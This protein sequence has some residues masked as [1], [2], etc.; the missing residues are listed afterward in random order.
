MEPLCADS[1]SDLRVKDEPSDS[2]SAIDGEDDVALAKAE[3]VDL[4]VLLFKVLWNETGAYAKWCSYVDRL[5]LALERLPLGTRE[6]TLAAYR[7][8]VAKFT[9]ENL[10]W[11]AQAREL[12][13]TLDVSPNVISM[14]TERRAPSRRSVPKEATTQR[15]V[16]V[17]QREVAM[18]AATPRQ[19]PV[20]SP[21]PF[22]RL[23]RMN[24]GLSDNGH[25]AVRQSLCRHCSGS[26][27]R[28][29]CPT[30]QRRPVENVEIRSVVPQGFAGISSATVFCR[31]RRGQNPRVGK[32]EVRT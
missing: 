16:Q 22:K 26:E 25:S 12:L 8:M 32:S 4:T 5:R 28:P 30:R 14:L 31:L 15:R 21:C 11:H 3:A 7:H 23:R 20:V 6:N 17:Q 10:S 19:E 13:I 1:Q 9:E 2:D 29:C 24:C 27:Q 18:A